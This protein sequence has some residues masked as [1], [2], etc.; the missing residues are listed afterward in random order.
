[1]KTKRRLLKLYK[2]LEK[3]SLKARGTDPRIR[4]FSQKP[5]SNPC[6]TIDL[7]DIKRIIP[8]QLA[9]HNETDT[10]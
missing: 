5:D 10:S 9:V 1:M 2:I 8:W 4:F 3:I 6:L 7:V